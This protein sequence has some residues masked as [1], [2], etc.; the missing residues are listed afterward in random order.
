[1]PSFLPFHAFPETAVLREF[2]Q[3]RSFFA[4]GLGG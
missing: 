4:F 3:L 2:D 1:M